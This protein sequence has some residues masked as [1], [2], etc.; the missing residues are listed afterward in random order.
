MSKFNPQI[1]RPQALLK[2]KKIVKPIFVSPLP[3]LILAKFLKEVNEISK[4]FKKNGNIPQKK[5]YVQAF[6]SSKQ[7][8]SK[9]STSTSSSSITMDILKIKKIFFN[10]L[11]KK[12]D[13]V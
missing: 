7:T 9:Q 1:S 12:I 6:S 8:T 10:L 2:G 11:N 5:L 3:L 13:L 4:Y